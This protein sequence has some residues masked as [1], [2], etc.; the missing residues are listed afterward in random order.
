M[1]V[2][3]SSNG[4]LYHVV[5]VVTDGIGCAWDQIKDREDNNPEDEAC[6]TLIAYD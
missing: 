5:K 3:E 1:I 2:S 6:D 4:A